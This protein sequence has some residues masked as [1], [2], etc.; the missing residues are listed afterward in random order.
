MEK[1]RREERR[2]HFHLHCFIA[3]VECMCERNKAFICESGYFFGSGD[4]DNF[5]CGVRVERKMLSKKHKVKKPVEK[6]PF[7]FRFAERKI[8]KLRMPI[9]KISI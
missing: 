8:N 2:F 7:L 6:F 9:S 1:K 5:V 4:V 3:E